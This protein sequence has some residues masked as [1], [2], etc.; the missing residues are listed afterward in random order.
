MKFLIKYTGQTEQRILTY[1]FAEYSFDI[2]PFVKFIDFD[3]VVN[4]LNLTVV[5]YHKVI[6]VWGYCGLTHS[7]KSNYEVPKS[8]K[9]LLIIV[10]DFKPGFSYRLTNDELPIYV[11]ARTGWI[12]IG[13]PLKLGNAVEFI[14]NCVAVIDEDKEF[15]ALWLKP[16]ILPALKTLEDS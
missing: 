9:G 8:E 12:C 15:V 2:E 14:N 7:I 4:K 1:N 16:H 13:N 6:Q 5:D 11:N 10:D 3:I